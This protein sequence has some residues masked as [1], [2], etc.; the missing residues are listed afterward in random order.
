MEIARGRRPRRQSRHREV[1]LAARAA[2]QSL[3]EVSAYVNLDVWRRDVGTYGARRVAKRR[4][5][6][7]GNTVQAKFARRLRALRLDRGLSQ[8]DMVRDHGWSLSHYQK[9][10][11]GTLDPR[12]TTV[13]ALAA[14]F[15]VE[16]GELL[17]FDET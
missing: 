9:L 14:A 1:L 16:A 13:F 12:L 17:E 2:E 6:R 11:R 8:M 15:D 10:E 5:P 4:H 3:R 7:E